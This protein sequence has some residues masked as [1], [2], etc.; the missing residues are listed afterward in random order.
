MEI[1]TSQSNYQ[2]VASSIAMPRQQPADA[3]MKNEGSVGNEG[4]FRN[5]KEEYEET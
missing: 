2:S 3:E 1:D 4:T 5:D